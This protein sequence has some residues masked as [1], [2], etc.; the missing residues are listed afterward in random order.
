[1]TE[2]TPELVTVEAVTILSTGTY[3]LGLNYVEDGLGTTFTESDLASAVEAMSDPQVRTPILKLGHGEGLVPGLPAFGQL[4]D[5]RLSED[6]QSL[7]C[8]LTG[9]PRWLA[10]VMPTAWPSRSIEGCE[11]KTDTREHRF[12][13]TALSLLG[14]EMPGVTRLPELEAWFG[15]DVPEGVTIPDVSATAAA[16]DAQA[17][18]DDVRRAFYS[19][20]G[21]NESDWWITAIRLSPDELI[22][23]DDNSGTL[24]RIPFEVGDQAEVS[25]G[26]PVAVV[27]TYSDVAAGGRIYANR[28][29]SEVEGDESERMADRVATDEEP[30]VEAGGDAADGVTEPAEPSTDAGGD[31][32]EP[33]GEPEESPVPVAASAADVVTM[34]AGAMA[35]LQADA[36]LGREAREQ[37]LS[38]RRTGIINAA[39]SDGKIPPA[40]REHWVALW[41]A[42]PEGTEQTIGQLAAGVVP[43]SELGTS[44]DASGGTGETAGQTAY[45]SEWLPEVANRNAEVAE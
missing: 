38:D 40:R 4:A 29:A 9:V 24:Y 14:I 25:F 45:P 16:V 39:V 13:V 35:S 41:Q 37:Q 6:G 7:L 30:N 2:T 42:D 15:A 1:M 20:I 18:A 44:T 22:V 32:G 10:E 34:D 21:R 23:K 11:L 28:S 12:V 17:D 36:K 33:E 31:E 26:D 5:L 43:V 27:V 8:D 3:A 19:T